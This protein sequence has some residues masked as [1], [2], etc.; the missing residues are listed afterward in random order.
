MASWKKRSGFTLVEML[1]VIA[2]IGVLV[3]LMLPAINMAREKAR[4]TQCANYQGQLGQAVLSYETSKQRFP[5][6]VNWVNPSVID[7]VNPKLRTNWIMAIFD[8]LGR[9]DVTKA[10]REWQ[11]DTTGNI[12]RPNTPIEQLVCPS[13]RSA[14]VE[15]GLSYVANMGVYQLNTAS[16]PDYSVRMFRDRTRPSN[17]YPNPESDLTSVSMK[18]SSRSI[19]LSERLDVGPWNTVTSAPT[20]NYGFNSMLDKI[21]FQWPTQYADNPNTNVPTTCTIGMVYAGDPG[22]NSTPPPNFKLLSSN[23]PGVIIV[24]FCD[25]H[26]EVLANE[27]KCWKDALG[28]DQADM[29]VV[30]GTP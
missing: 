25:G 18:T 10:I 19:M 5:G 29:A 24:T 20:A 12:P 7:L 15:G 30:Y 14:A 6:V 21:A 8:D 27:T 17:N 23:H 1:V 22:G 16:T 13:N 4:Q 26:T 3:A 11:A 28:R 2:I 9:S